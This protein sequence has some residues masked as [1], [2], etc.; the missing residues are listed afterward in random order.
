MNTNE[1]KAPKPLFQQA[2]NLQLGNRAT[3]YNGEA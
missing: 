1:R 3:M 2:F